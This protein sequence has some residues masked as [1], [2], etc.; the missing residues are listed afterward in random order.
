MGGEHST[1]DA[2][3]MDV[4]TR[5]RH[6]Y[7]FGWGAD[8]SDCF[9][10]LTYKS[11]LFQP[12]KAPFIFVDSIPAS[13]TEFSSIP[14]TGYTLT[15]RKKAENGQASVRYVFYANQRKQRISGRQR[16]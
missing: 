3:K 11:F 7:S 12:A 8:S 4:I 10:C 9:Y 2:Y 13:T 14:P 1:L 15:A 16:R 5:I 6:T